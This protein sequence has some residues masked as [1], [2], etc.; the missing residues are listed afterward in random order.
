[1]KQSLSRRILSLITALVLL[2]LTGLPGGAATGAVVAEVVR[3][4]PASRPVRPCVAAARSAYSTS[5][6]R[7]SPSGP[8]PVISRRS[9]P[10]CRASLRTSGEITGTGSR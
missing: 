7:I 6:R 10:F 4:S 3:G 1:M 8:E 9:S 2:G 5:A